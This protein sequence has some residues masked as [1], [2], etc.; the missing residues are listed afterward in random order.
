MD[1]LYVLN[2]ILWVLGNV[3]LMYGAIALSIY[4]VAYFILFDPR[5]TTGGKL[6]FQFMVSLISVMLIVVIGVYVDP[7]S[8][9]AWNE[10]SKDVAWWRPGLRFLAYGFV[11]YSVTS[12]AVLLVMR[13]W[14]PHKLKKASDMSL[15]QPRHTASIDII[16]DSEK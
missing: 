12:L 8:N 1:I 13:K 5:A 16:D 3:L 14:F 7:S 15:V 4:L 2:H 9:H 6:I 11:A 10:L